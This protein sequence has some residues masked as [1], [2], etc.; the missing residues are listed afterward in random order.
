M[1]TD[2][3]TAAAEESTFI[4]TAAFTDEDGDA[5]VPDSITWTLTD[6]DGT[7]INNREDVAV[8]SPAASIDIVLSGDDLALQTGESG[9][10]VR[11]LT[12]KAVVDL[13]AENDKPV[14]DQVRFVIKDLSAVT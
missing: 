6:T 5:A 11:V 1:P 8:G 10:V 13:A 7:V 3:T 12:I 9:D 4:I 14:R 2:L